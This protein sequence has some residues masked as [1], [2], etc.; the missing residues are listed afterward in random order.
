MRVLEME[1]QCEDCGI[2]V[3]GDSTAVDLPDDESGARKPIIAGR[4]RIVGPNSGFYQPD[5]IAVPTRT[6]RRRSASRSWKSTYHIDRSTWRRAAGRFLS[7]RASWQQIIIT[8]FR[9]RSP[10][11]ASTRKRLW[12]H[13]FAMRVLPLTSRRKSRSSLSCCSCATR[14]SLAEI[15]LFG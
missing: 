6:M 3:E 7:M 13:A 9:K 8:T 1:Y 14:G 10:N 5:S 11:G 15:T 2:I 12:P 4:L